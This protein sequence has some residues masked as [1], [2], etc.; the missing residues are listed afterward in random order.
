MIGQR[1]NCWD[2]VSQWRGRLGRGCRSLAAGGWGRPC[3]SA[4][5]SEKPYLAVTCTAPVNIAVI[6]YCECAG[7]G[8][9]RRGLQ[10]G[11]GGRRKRR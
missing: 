4:M 11:A 9:A 6:K 3:A 1:A 2:L 7:R 8:C 10:P 5:A